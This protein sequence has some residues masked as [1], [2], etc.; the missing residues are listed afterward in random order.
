MVSFATLAQDRY[1][2]NFKVARVADFDRSGLVNVT[3]AEALRH[4]PPREQE[5]QRRYRAIDVDCNATIVVCANAHDAFCTGTSLVQS[6][7]ANAGYVVMPHPHLSRS[8]ANDGDESDRNDSGLEGVEERLEEYKWGLAISCPSKISS[9]IHWRKDKCVYQMGK[10][11]DYKAVYNVKGNRED[12][13]KNWRDS[14]RKEVS[15][16]LRII[17]LGGEDKKGKRHAN[18]EI[19]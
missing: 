19:G 15:S 4:P 17:K 7:S 3:W 8:D 12:T 2:E 18:T 9:G 14:D 10:G 5:A 13:R 11:I 1:L 6:A 16:E